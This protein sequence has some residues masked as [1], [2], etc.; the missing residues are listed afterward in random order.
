MILR[1]QVWIQKRGY[2]NLRVLSFC[3]AFKCDQE[4]LQR[5]LH[6]DHAHVEGWNRMN[7]QPT[8]HTVIAISK[9]RGDYFLSP[10][11]GC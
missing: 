9:L 3:R 11:D 7:G 5:E 1:G 2:V 8:N 4:E 10:L 6:C